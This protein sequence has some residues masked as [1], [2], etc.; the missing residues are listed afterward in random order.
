MGRPESPL[1]DGITPELRAYLLKLRKLRDSLGLRNADL[2]A[3]IHVSRT[4]V[5]RLLNASVF[6]QGQAG[7][8]L[9]NYLTHQSGIGEH[10]LHRMA[11]D[12]K[13]AEES[14]HLRPSA[15]DYVPLHPGMDD[16]FALLRLYQ[17]LGEPPLRVLAERTGM[18]RMT[19]HRALT[20]SNNARVR[21]VFG[22]LYALAPPEFQAEYTYQPPSESRAAE[23]PQQ[24]D[25]EVPCAAP[26]LERFGLTAIE[27]Q[28][29]DQVADG[30]NNQQITE[31][32]KVSI[33]V[34]RKHRESIATKM[35]VRTSREAR[36]M[37]VAATTR[38]RNPQDSPLPHHVE[39][40]RLYLQVANRRV[41]D[42][43]RL[44]S[45]DGEHVPDEAVLDDLLTAL[46]SAAHLVQKAQFYI[47]P[48]AFP[49]F[50]EAYEAPVPYEVPV[51]SD[52]PPVEPKRLPEYDYDDLAD[53]SP[54]TE[55]SERL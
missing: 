1:P 33:D 9:R 4:T 42:W 11:E 7:R 32:T 31:A 15:E 41:A 10:V 34:V 26:S 18:S 2:A 54:D 6:P 25:A 20:E 23:P 30:R 49:D 38:P 36:E 44:A 47:A 8:A 17:Q 55:R 53:T 21:T 52:E 37:W 22:A 50:E 48:P 35:G 19:L 45:G 5:T 51:L 27:I 40:L 3:A 24:D 39:M 28:V 46:Q 13:R 29:M 12:A 14:K 43:D 16:D